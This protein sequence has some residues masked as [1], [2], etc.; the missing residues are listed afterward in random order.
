DSGPIVGQENGIARIGRVVLHAGGLADSNA[1]QMGLFFKPGHILSRLVC[2]SRNRIGIVEKLLRAI[3]WHYTS[4]AKQT[5]ASRC[6]RFGLSLRRVIGFGVVHHFQYM[7]FDDP[8]HAIQI[9][10]A[11]AFEYIGIFRLLTKEN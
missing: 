7:S 3:L 4:P 2:N 1:L 11:V 5:S 9:N 6:N 8:P 10:A